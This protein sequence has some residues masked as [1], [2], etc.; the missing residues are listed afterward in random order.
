MT[1][2]VDERL[3]GEL[4]SAACALAPLEGRRSP[5]CRCSRGHRP[6]G[7]DSEARDR[8][9]VPPQRHP[10]GVG[11]PLTQTPLRRACRP[12]R[13]SSILMAHAHR[14]TDSAGRKYHRPRRSGRWYG[15]ARAHRAPRSRCRVR[16]IGTCDH[17]VPL[18]A[19]PR[20]DRRLVRKLFPRGRFG[21]K[22]PGPRT[23]PFAGSL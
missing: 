13:P 5:G 21:P 3:R 8:L 9:G 12:Q 7:S 6:S 17:P 23:S 11:D 4:A 20:T 18:R 2:Q 16:Q 14:G 15:R 10:S 19:K 1:S 22:H